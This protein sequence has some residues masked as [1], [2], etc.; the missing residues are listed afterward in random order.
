MIQSKKNFINIVTGVVL[1]EPPVTGGEQEGI[2]LSARG[3]YSRRCGADVS[4]VSGIP[5]FSL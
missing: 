3:G 5:G 4:E 1:S 2:K